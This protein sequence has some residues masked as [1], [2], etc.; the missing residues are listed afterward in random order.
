MSD[1]LTS[2]LRELATEGER[3]PALTGAETLRF[4]GAIHGSVDE[5]YRDDLIRLTVVHRVS[6]PDLLAT[7]LEQ[8]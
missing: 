3:P 7:Q 1:E 4:L 8:L 6:E 2:V 5:T